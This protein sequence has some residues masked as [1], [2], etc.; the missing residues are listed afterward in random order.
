MPFR[1]EQQRKFLY[2][3]KPEVASRWAKAYGTPKGLP[4]KV[5]KGRWERLAKEKE[6]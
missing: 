5:R 6:K 1:S 2:A 4:K 3:R